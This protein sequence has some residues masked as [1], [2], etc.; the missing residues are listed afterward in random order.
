MSFQPYERI[1]RILVRNRV[2]DGDGDGVEVGAAAL[3]GFPVPEEQSTELVIIRGLL[4]NF[5][6]QNLRFCNFRLPQE[7]PVSAGICRSNLMLENRSSC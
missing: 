5:Q 4:S 3:G 2:G 6:V 7:G 1:V